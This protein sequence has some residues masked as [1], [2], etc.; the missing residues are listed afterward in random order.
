M[1]DDPLPTIASELTAIA[2]HAPGPPGSFYFSPAQHRARA[3]QL[4]R[5]NP[6]SRAA[7]LAELAANA[8]EDR[9]RGRSPLP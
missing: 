8:I 9:L 6:N 5:S 7:V 2:P 3:K 4:R 1:A